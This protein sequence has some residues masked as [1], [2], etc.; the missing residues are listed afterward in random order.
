MT[1]SGNALGTIKT[2][3]QNTAPVA[4]IL[5]NMF[6]ATFPEYYGKYQKAFEAGVFFEQDPGPWLGRAIV[7][8]LDGGLHTD[9]KDVGPAACVPCGH[10]S[11]GTLLFPQFKGKFK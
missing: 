10:F 7:Y 5:G 2:Y 6:A 3:Y 4:K 11:G 1:K 9:R 8:K